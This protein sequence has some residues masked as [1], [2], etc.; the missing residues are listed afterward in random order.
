M[1]SVQLSEHKLL[2]KPND[3]CINDNDYHPDDKMVELITKRIGCN[4]PWSKVKV[5]SVED[6]SHESDFDRYLDMVFKHQMDIMNIPKK[7]HFDTWIISHSEEYSNESKEASVVF[8]MLST[9][10]QVI[11][12]VDV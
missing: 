6:C 11:T 7:C 2:S 5:E 10:G 3:I 12:L 8:D 9:E 1:K 4:L